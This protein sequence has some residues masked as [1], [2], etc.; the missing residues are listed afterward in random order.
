V[1]A[2]SAEEAR[3]RATVTNVAIDFMMRVVLGWV[4]DCKLY[5]GRDNRPA[6]RI[7]RHE[8]VG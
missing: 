3:V 5:G 7:E 4:N 1:G 6:K 2:A 8:Q